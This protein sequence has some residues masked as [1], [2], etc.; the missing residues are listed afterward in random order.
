MN[1]CV[2]FMMLFSHSSEKSFKVTQCKCVRMMT[3][4][5]R[6]GSERQWIGVGTQTLSNQINLLSFYTT[7]AIEVIRS[8]VKL[9]VTRSRRHRHWYIQGTRPTFMHQMIEN[10]NGLRFELVQILWWI[11]MFLT[12][13]LYPVPPS[14][15]TLFISISIHVSYSIRQWIAQTLEMHLWKW[16]WKM[17][18]TLIILRL[19]LTL[20]LE[21]TEKPF[22]WTNHRMHH[23][24]EMCH[25]SF[26]A[27]S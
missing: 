27:Y 18:L 10:C 19:P 7:L 22:R 8:T 13:I 25:F 17:N 14:F 12:G 20:H 26:W 1:W 6:N 5:I 3:L 11:W 2:E 24:R 23:L 4:V 9:V 16:T 15:P 21:T